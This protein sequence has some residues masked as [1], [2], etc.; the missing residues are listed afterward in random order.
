MSKRHL[1]LGERNNI[2]FKVGTD[3]KNDSLRL[4]Y[5]LFL[6]ERFNGASDFHDIELSE[7]AAEMLATL[8]RQALE[9]SMSNRIHSLMQGCGVLMSDANIIMRKNTCIIAHATTGKNKFF[10]QV[11]SEGTIAS[12]VAESKK[13][14]RI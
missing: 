2:Y 4:R 9:I 5:N 7:S 11:V 8:K 10:M 6:A 1:C 3:S 12:N 13:Q 14:S